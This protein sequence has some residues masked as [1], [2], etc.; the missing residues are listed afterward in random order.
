MPREFSTPMF[1]S[2]EER[3][4]L[5]GTDIEGMLILTTQMMQVGLTCTKN[6]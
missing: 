1:W 4:A 3:K 2:E 5:K 6:A